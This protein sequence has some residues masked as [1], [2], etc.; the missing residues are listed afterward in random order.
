MQN[1]ANLPALLQSFFTTRLMTQRKRSSHHRLLSRHVSPATSVRA[2]TVTQGP[3]SVGVER[4]GRRFDRRIPGR[5]GKP[6]EQRAEEPKP[7]V[8]GH[9]VILPLRRIGSAGAERNHPTGTGHSKPTAATSTG[10]FPD[11]AGDRSAVG[12][13]GSNDMAGTPRPCVPDYR[14]SDRPAIVRDDSV[15]PR[16]CFARNRSSCAVPGQGAQGTLHT[17]GQTHRRCAQSV[18]S[19]AR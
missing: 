3:L 6:P 15:A 19:R 17:L 7:A 16:R 14:R 11:A 10:G 2:E 18:D 12:G 8:D 13:A 1:P 4:S 9:P 5:S